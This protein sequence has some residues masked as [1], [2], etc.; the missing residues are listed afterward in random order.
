M[1]C[2]FVTKREKGN[3]IIV[4][5]KFNHR[6]WE[7]KVFKTSSILYLWDYLVIRNSTE[8]RDGVTLDVKELWQLE[9]S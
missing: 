3:Y 6:I 4:V 7:K 8:Q 2:V 9:W 1:F 5:A